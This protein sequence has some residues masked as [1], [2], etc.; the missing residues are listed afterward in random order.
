MVKVFYFFRHGE[1]E[2]NRQKRWQGSGMDYDLNET[3]IQQAQDL[4]EKL[5][6]KG[7]EVIFSSPLIRAKHTADA[8]AACL[9]TDVLVRADLRECFYGA[10]EGQLISDLQRDYPGVAENWSKPGEANWALRFP[11]GESKGE[12]LHRVWAEIEKL[13]AESYQ[14]AGVAIHGGTMA[15]LLNF[16]NYDFDKIP[17]CGV[18]RMDYENGSGKVIGNIF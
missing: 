7:L 9:G 15:A 8:V 1:T 17:N 18:F 6:G 5:T 3:G 13:A 4:A 14:T 11:Q 2:L 12:A 10:A 16:L